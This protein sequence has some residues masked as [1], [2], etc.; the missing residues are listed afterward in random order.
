M[1]LPLPPDSPS[2]SMDTLLR[3]GI[4]GRDFILIENPV[5]NRG[6]QIPPVL[7]PTEFQEIAYRNIQTAWAKLSGAD[8]DLRVI[9]S[10]TMRLMRAL[11]VVNTEGAA[12][13]EVLLL[14]FPEDIGIAIA[15]KDTPDIRQNALMDQAHYD[16]DRMAGQNIV[17]YTVTMPIGGCN[18]SIKNWEDDIVR[19]F[20]IGQPELT[21]IQGFDRRVIGGEV[22]KYHWKFRYLR[23]MDYILGLG[24]RVTLDWDPAR[25]EYVAIMHNIE[26]RLTGEEFELVLVDSGH[27]SELRTYKYYDPEPLFARNIPNI[28]LSF[29]A[30]RESFYRFLKD[31]S[32]NPF[33]SRFL[34]HSTPEH[35][36][37]SLWR[38]NRILAIFKPL[39]SRCHLHDKD[40]LSPEDRD[41]MRAVKEMN[42]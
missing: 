19:S 15:K 18:Y 2:P 1:P 10:L 20:E 9:P 37:A 6:V 36:S 11:I 22:I 28:D 34:E 39:E 13:K 32:R 24:D 17:P 27:N 40:I 26:F 35:R 3:Q 12:E 7:Y 29:F 33:G 23:L 38:L 8:K 41:R 31:I 14:I 4:Y 5:D 16:F 21:L 30:P 25:G 42:L